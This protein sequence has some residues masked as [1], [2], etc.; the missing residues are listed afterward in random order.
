[1]I[2][3]DKILAGRNDHCILGAAVVKPSGNVR[4]RKEPAIDV[5][6]AIIDAQLVARLRDYAF[7]IAFLGIARVMKNHHVAAMDAGK[8]VEEFIDKQAV[9]VSQARQHAGA[10]HPH[11]LIEKSDDEEGDRERKE[12]IATPEPEN[13]PRQL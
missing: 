13:A 11:W 7:D 4:L 1:M 6:A 3:H 8:V 2:A 12:H 5:G 9:L 10:F